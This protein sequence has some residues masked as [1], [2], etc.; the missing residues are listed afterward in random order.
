MMRTRA[1]MVDSDLCFGSRTAKSG[2]FVLLLCVVLVSRLML[3]SCL[4]PVL[5]FRSVLS[6]SLQFFVTACV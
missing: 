6:V 5:P 4:L 2:S 1:R 3:P